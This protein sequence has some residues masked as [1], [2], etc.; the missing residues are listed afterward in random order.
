MG[1]EMM[2]FTASA[3]L[4]GR[5]WAPKPLQGSGGCGAP[6]PQWV[7]SWDVPSPRRRA[8]SQ[9]ADL[10]AKLFLQE[11]LTGKTRQAA[12]GD[13]GPACSHHSPAPVCPAAAQ[14]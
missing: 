11:P 13:R 1:G 7:P 5:T 3:A 6:C 10:A 14:R 2:P 9:A 4:G 12:G 8:H